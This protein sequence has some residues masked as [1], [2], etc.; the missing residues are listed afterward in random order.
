[1]LVL[2]YSCPCWP[3]NSPPAVA[4]VAQ[5]E[6]HP[7]EKH[8]TYSSIVL[9]AIFATP[10]IS[11]IAKQISKIYHFCNSFFVKGKTVEELEEVARQRL[12][13]HMFQMLQ[14]AKDE[15]D[16]PKALKGLTTS[17]SLGER[18]VLE[19]VEHF[20][21]EHF[22]E[23]LKGAHFHLYD[24]ADLYFV[25]GV[26]ELKKQHRQSSHSSDGFSQFSIRGNFLK[27]N[28]FSVKVEDDGRKYTWLQLEAHPVTWKEILQAIGH[29]WTY[30]QYLHTGMNQGPYGQSIHTDRNPIIIKKPYIPENRSPQPTDNVDWGKL[31]L[32]TPMATDLRKQR[33]L[34]ITNQI[35]QKKAQ[36]CEKSKLERQRQRMQQMRQ[37]HRTMPL[38][39]D[40]SS[41]QPDMGFSSKVKE[42]NNCRGQNGCERDHNEKPLESSV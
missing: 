8:R 21:Q 37:Q 25:W 23:F 42:E 18:V 27:E 16:Y 29:L 9:H 20:S 41:L 38:L 28:L 14:K 11:W 26:R 24:N 40:N 22:T 19:T 15:I 30:I 31:Q 33:K 2:G 36:K 12:S 13:P 6:A 17:L 39:S 7:N 4:Q 34:E 10:G 5:E 35:E 3:S 32:T 1:M